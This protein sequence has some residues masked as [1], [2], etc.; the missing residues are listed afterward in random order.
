MEIT[1][2][3][4]KQCPAF[5]LPTMKITAMDSSHSMLAVVLR[6]PHDRPHLDPFLRTF[7][8]APSGRAFAMPDGL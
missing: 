1:A 4:G 3:R 7:S 2:A 5:I 6:S 8:G